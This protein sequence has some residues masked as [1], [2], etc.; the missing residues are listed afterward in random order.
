MYF[1]Q[2]F[3]VKQD[4]S[5]LIPSIPATAILESSED[6]VTEH[7]NASTK[8]RELNWAQ[9]WPHNLQLATALVLII[10]IVIMTLGEVCLWGFLQP[11][12]APMPNEVLYNL[13]NHPSFA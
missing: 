4:I 12:L 3:C 6:R 10:A 11:N 5:V 13:H 2:I 1:H 8:G 7:C 9:L